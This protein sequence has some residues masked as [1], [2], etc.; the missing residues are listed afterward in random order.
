MKQTMAQSLQASGVIYEMLIFRTQSQKFLV[1]RHWFSDIA[2]NAKEKNVYLKSA[3]LA[4]IATAM[5]LFAGIMA[6]LPAKSADTLYFD[7]GIFGRTLSVSSLET[8]AQEGTVD[9]E[10]FQSERWGEFSY[11][12]PVPPGDYQVIL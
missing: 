5:G 6:T 1:C 3:G 12:I 10:L 4:L 9:D 2:S 8:F 7:Y 11:S